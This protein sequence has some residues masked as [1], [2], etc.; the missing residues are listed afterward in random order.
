[1]SPPWSTATTCHVH[2]LWFC[3]GLNHHECSFEIWN[4]QDVWSVIVSAVCC[5][6]NNSLYIVIGHTL[7]WLANRFDFRWS[8]GQPWITW[9]CIVWVMASEQVICDLYVARW[10]DQFYALHKCILMT[11]P[12]PIAILEHGRLNSLR[13]KYFISMDSQSCSLKFLRCLPLVSLVFLSF[14]GAGSF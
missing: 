1:M 14:N 5:T 12:L 6:Q 3:K 2:S 8:P 7:H 9:P 10:L 4:L 13:K 11:L